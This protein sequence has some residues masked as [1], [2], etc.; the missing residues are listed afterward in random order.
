MAVTVIPPEPEKKTE[1]TNAE[2]F[3]L[4]TQ[5]EVQAFYASIDAGNSMLRLVR[6]M[7]VG[8]NLPLALDNPLVTNGLGVMVLSGVIT[9]ERAQEIAQGK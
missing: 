5:E 1:Y 7:L 9:E 6:D 4:F 2:F 3:A 8:T